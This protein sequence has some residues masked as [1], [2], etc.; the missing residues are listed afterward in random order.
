M[1]HQYLNRQPILGQSHFSSE[2]EAGTNCLIVWG[3]TC[4]TSEKCF[5]HFPANSYSYLA[6]SN[7]WGTGWQRSRLILWREMARDL[8]GNGLKM[9][10][11]TF[12]AIQHIS[13]HWKPRTIYHSETKNCCMTATSIYNVLY[14]D[15]TIGISLNFTL[16]IPPDQLYK[17]PEPP[18]D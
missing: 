11:R 5:E 16:L 6:S 4:W 3:W 13:S 17:V 12:Q 18:N 10:F 2:F 15:W 1:Q 8:H 9:C 14:T 7:L